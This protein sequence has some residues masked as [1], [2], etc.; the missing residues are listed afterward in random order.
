MVGRRPVAR[1]LGALLWLALGTAGASGLQVAPVSLTL[2]PGE[3]SQALWLSNS[4]EVPLHAQVRVYRWQQRDGQESLESTRDLVAS[5]PMIEIA[6]GQTQLVRVVRPGAPPDD[7]EEA[8]Y[9]LLINELPLDRPEKS[10]VDFVMEYSLP[11]FLAPST[12]AGEQLRWSLVRVANG[13]RLRVSNAGNGHARLSALSVEGGG[14]T[15]AVADGLLGYVLPGSTMEWDLPARAA[16]A[17]AAGGRLR[18][19]VNGRTVDSVA[20]AGPSG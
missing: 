19:T 12:R 16:A 7:G 9:R 5:P 15:N 3:H 4:G 20:L 1:L 17:L 8:A 6:P 11:V 18:A 10:G 13:T 14:G 2:T